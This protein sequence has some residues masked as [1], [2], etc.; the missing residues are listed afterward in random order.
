VTVSVDRRPGRLV[1]D[2]H[3]EGRRRRTPAGN[4]SG[5]LGMR[6]RAASVGGE[7]DAGPAPDGGWHVTATLPDVRSAS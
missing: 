5:L 3:D 2:V 6:E 1:L 7:V 4:G